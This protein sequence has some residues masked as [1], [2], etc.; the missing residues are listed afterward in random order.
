M[1]VTIGEEQPG[2]STLNAYFDVTLPE[3]IDK[4]TVTLEMPILKYNKS[5]VFSYITDDTYSIY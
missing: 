5:L 1:T 3:T 2:F 4:E